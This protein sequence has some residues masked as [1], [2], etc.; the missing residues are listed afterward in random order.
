MDNSQQRRSGDWR[1]SAACAGRLSSTFYPPPR[2]ED[3]FTRRQRESRAKAVCATC[4]VRDDCLDHAIS[5]DE[6]YGIWGGLNGRERRRL[7]A[8]SLAG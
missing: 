4:A 5:N 1:D 7:V 2:S 6:R 8:V 3:K